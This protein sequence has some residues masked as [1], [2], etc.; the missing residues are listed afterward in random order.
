M[1]DAR[2]SREGS[3]VQWYVRA[4]RTRTYVCFAVYSLLSTLWFLIDP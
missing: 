3:L 1:R 2:E 4:P